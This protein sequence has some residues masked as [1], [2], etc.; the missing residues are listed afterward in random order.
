MKNLY[1][2]RHA[3]SSWKYDVSDHE[4]PLKKRGTSDAHLVSNYLK[5]KIKNPDL[6][7]SSD[8]NRAKTTAEIFTSNLG[9]NGSLIQYDH[10]LYDFSGF[11]LINVIKECNDAVNTL[12]IFGHNYALTHFVNE[13]GDKYVDNV[14]TSGFTHIVFN[15]DSWMD[16]NK[17]KTLLTVFPR[18]LKNK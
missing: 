5:D 8:A 7:I 9:I 12:M 10:E 11:K 4:R 17:G 6:V 13:F 15:I 14:T 16:L 18:D 2:V 1:L 3:K